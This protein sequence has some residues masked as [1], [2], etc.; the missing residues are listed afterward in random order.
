M[1]NQHLATLFFA[2]IAA[3][4]AIATE[5]TW[6]A[7]D[8]A[9]SVAL[10]IAWLVI[11]QP[12]EG[13]CYIKQGYDGHPDKIEIIVKDDNTIYLQSPF[14]HEIDS[15]I[16]YWVDKGPA[17][18]APIGLSLRLSSDLIPELIR[19][20]ILTVEFKPVGRE[21]MQQQFSLYGFTKAHE[22]L[23]SSTCKEKAPEKD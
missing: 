16:T 18:K 5:P 20:A 14:F 21:A 9:N 11:R 23:S 15:G 2:L 12:N 13:S 8:K 1:K 3:S 22:W 7:R 6:N 17:R 19:G 4:D 10:E